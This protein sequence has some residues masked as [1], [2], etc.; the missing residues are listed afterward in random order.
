[1]PPKRPPPKKTGPKV[2]PDTLIHEAMT[3]LS[4]LKAGEPKECD[5]CKM[6]GSFVS[7]TLS[8]LD[9]DVRVEAIAHIMQ[10]L[11]ALKK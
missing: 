7:F 8:T 3:T 1:M 6:T 5:E 2:D 4:T 10:Y 11:L 9:K